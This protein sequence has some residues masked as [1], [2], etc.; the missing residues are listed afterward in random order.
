M[1]SKR[2]LGRKL[3]SV[4]VSKDG[5]WNVDSLFFISLSVQCLPVY[6]EGFVNRLY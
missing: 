1:N 3:L 2:T 6:T 5:I 4:H